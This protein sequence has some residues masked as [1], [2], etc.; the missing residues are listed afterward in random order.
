MTPLE[1][2]LGLLPRDVGLVDF[3]SDRQSAEL[4]SG[5][6]DEAA[7]RPSLELGTSYADAVAAVEETDLAAIGSLADAVED[8]TEGGAAFSQVDVRWTM[9]ANDR[10]RARPTTT[11]AWSRCSDWSTASTWPTVAADLEDAGFAR[12]ERRQAGITSTSTAS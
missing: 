12:L 2:A 9:R 7:P 5:L 6:L 11:A 10:R 3:S 1:E 4:D 8:M